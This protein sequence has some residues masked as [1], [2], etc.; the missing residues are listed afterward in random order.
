MASNPLPFV[1]P[2]GNLSSEETEASLMLPAPIVWVKVFVACI[3]DTQYE[4]ES[5]HLFSLS[6]RPR[7]NE[8]SETR[9]FNLL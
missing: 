9:V 2:L 8:T 4:Q 3:A 5:N 6:N 1:F 7:I